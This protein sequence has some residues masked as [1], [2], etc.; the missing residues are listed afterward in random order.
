MG[1]GDV[2]HSAKQHVSTSSNSADGPCVAG[3]ARGLFFAAVVLL[4]ALIPWV[5]SGTYALYF[6]ES[7]FG[8]IATAVTI[9]ICLVLILITK[10]TTKV[11]QVIALLL[12]LIWAAVAGIMTFRAP[13]LTTGNGYFASYAGL[14]MAF[15]LSA[16]AC[17]HKC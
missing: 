17:L 3:P 9:V 6:D 13:F 16:V 2:M 12:C 14:F 1:L 10:L 7:L 5:D 15:H 11:V 8:M 4:I